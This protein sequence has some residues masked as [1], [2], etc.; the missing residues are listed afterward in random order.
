MGTRVSSRHRFWFRLTRALGLLV[1][2]SG[3]AGCLVS[4]PPQYEE[5]GITP[6]FLDLVAATPLPGRIIARE[7]QNGD[8]VPFDVPFRSEDNGESLRFAMYRNFSFAAG[9]SPDQIIIHPRTLPPGTFD[10][11]DRAIRFDAE[12]K[13][14]AGCHQLTLLVAHT[15]SWDETI[16]RPHPLRSIGDTAMA[17]WW[18]NYYLPGQDPSQLVDCPTLSGIEP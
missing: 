15:S 16:V 12:I 7:F 9:L 3:P 11:T 6:P 14:S 17:T 2:A 1:L 18:L 13:A 8:A 5:P 4:D 10:E